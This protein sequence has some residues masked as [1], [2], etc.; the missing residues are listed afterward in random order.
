MWG[1]ISGFSS[2]SPRLIHDPANLATHSTEHRSSFASFLPRLGEAVFCSV[3]RFGLR[4]V[5]VL[6]PFEI[7]LC[8]ASG[9]A[10][11]VS[12]GPACRGA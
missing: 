7:G 6:T 1:E 10:V 9:S 5:F 8:F 2:V 3:L 11:L 12:L 4:F